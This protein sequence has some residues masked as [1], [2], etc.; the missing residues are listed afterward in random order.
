MGVQLQGGCKSSFLGCGAAQVAPCCTGFFHEQD[1]T[2]NICSGWDGS[3]TRLTVG[4]PVASGRSQPGIFHQSRA[5][6]R[7]PSADR[8]GNHTALITPAQFSLIWLSLGATEKAI[9]RCR[10]RM[11]ARSFS[12][13]RTQMGFRR[14]P[15]ASLR[16]PAHWERAQQAD[17][18]GWTRSLP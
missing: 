2:Q 1:W 16:I 11:K 12:S 4:I 15:V 9:S 18:R 6:E 14:V 3:C 10:A 7:L 8:I 13:P 17:N 5:A